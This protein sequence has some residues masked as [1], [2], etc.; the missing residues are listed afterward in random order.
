MSYPQQ[1]VML[2]EACF[3]K[4]TKRDK[5][6]ER[7][8]EASIVSAFRNLYWNEAAPWTKVFW[9]GHQ[10]AKCPLDLWVYQEI[11]E[12]TKPELI[13]ETGSSIGGSALFFATIGRAWVLTVDKDAYPNQPPHQR[14]RYVVGDSIDRQIIE[15][16]R[17]RASRKRT[18]VVLDS[19][20]TYEHVAAELE[21]YGDL[22]SPGCYLVV[23]DT[24][25]DESWGKRAAG[26]AARE[27]VAAHTGFVVDTSREKH[28]L[29]LNPGGWIRRDF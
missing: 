3:E 28:L 19:L 9:R 22:V 26:A 10:V 7:D 15:A 20:H 6:A 5:D 24:A 17:P 1:R 13:I 18:M 4:A 11:I 21:A 2:C 25:V 12:E 8:K 27:F 23:E 14:I 16:I 29:T